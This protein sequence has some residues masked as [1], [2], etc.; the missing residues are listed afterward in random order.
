MLAHFF[1]PFE[2]LIK[3]QSKGLYDVNTGGSVWRALGG[4]FQ[5][6]GGIGGLFWPSG[7]FTF[8]I[9]FLFWVWGF[10]FL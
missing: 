2:P 8:P 1:R 7:L 10:P 3:K 6:G 9:F 4:G 5:E